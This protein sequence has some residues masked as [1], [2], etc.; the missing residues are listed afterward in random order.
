MVVRYDALREDAAGKVASHRFEV[1]VPGV[2]PKV[3]AVAPALNKAAKE[4]AS[5][6]ADWVG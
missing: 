2:S 3:E 1:T 4:V 6:V 5:Q